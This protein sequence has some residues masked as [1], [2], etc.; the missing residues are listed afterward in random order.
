M[1]NLKHQLKQ[2]IFFVGIGG[3]GMAPLAE[4]LHTKKLQ[5][6]GSDQ[7]ESA[8][9]LRLRELGVAVAIGHTEANV[10]EAGTLVIS[11]AIRPDN[12][13][14]VAAQK[15][16]VPILHRSDILK[17]LTD[18]FQTITVAGTHGKTTTTAM[19]AFMLHELGCKPTAAVG[20]D[21]LN[22]GSHALVGDGE[23]FVAEADESDGSFVKYRSLV[24]VLTNVEPD[25]M[26]YF[27][28]VERQVEVFTEYLQNTDPD[29][30]AIVG[31][32]FKLARDVGVKFTGNRL[33]F[34][35]GIGVDVRAINYQQQGTTATFKAIVERDQIDVSLKMIGKHNV[36]NA[37]CALSVCRALDL[38]IKEGA[39]ALAKFSGVGRR[40]SL[41]HANKNVTIYDDYAHNPGKIAACVQS[42][43]Q[44]WPDTKLVVIY[45]P[46][47]YSRIRTMYNDSVAAFSGADRVLLLPVY[48]AGEAVDDQYK[49]ED[50]AGDIA[51][52][53]ATD[54]QVCSWTE[55]AHL[56][57]D[58][59]D[60]P[61]VILTLGAGDVWKI[62]QEIKKNLQ[63]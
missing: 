44:T 4:I 49:A 31:W 41:V 7:N 25:H 33:A 1:P 3:S 38:D 30:F 19:I 15:A 39:K 23:Y 34:G 8:N 57:V 58:A 29:G 42:L 17:V 32:D 53:S 6:A 52:N 27:K 56:A 20:G 13:E 50:Y 46:H 60:A 63:G 12:P 11:S 61:T 28:S 14:Y 22:F 54:C 10:A 55:A 2:P 5:V 36:L 16:G 37:L 21:M 48:A 26:D 24:S 59:T 45:Q 9:T 35:L 62:G 43:R 40:L 47:R 51:Q 18:S